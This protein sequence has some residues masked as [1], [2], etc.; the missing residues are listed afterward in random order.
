MKKGQKMSEEQRLGMCGENNPMFGRIG[1]KHH[2]YGTKHSSQT[3]EL[4]IKNHLGMKGKRHS[5]ETKKR[6]S[7]SQTGKTRTEETKRKIGEASRNRPSISEE[8][9]KNMS[10]SHLGHKTSEETKRK[11]GEKNKI[12]CKGKKQTESAKQKI[13]EYQISHP[14]RSF[15][16]TNIEK[17]AEEELKFRNINYKKQFPLYG[18]AK[19]DFYLPEHKIVIQCD[20]CFWHGCPTCDLRKEKYKREREEKQ[21]LVLK[22]NGLK[23]FRFWGHEIEKDIK[24]CI[25][26]INFN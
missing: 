15:K 5:D 3:K 25:N 4:M 8:T 1:E 9:R 11:I 18:I 19:V 13:R 2:L 16:D 20:G 23:V 10:R 21:D 6:M 26:R 12:S 14:N 17:I 7:L 22:E 24:E